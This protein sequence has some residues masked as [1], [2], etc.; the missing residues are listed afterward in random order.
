MAACLASGCYTGL[1]YA[2]EP[3]D[4][5][6]ADESGGSTGVGEEP[7][8]ASTSGGEEPPEADVCA[9]LPPRTRRLTMAQFD[10]LVAQIAPSFEGVPSEI[11]APTLVGSAARFEGAADELTMPA[12]H[13]DALLD[14][15]DDLSPAVLE[16]LDGWVSCDATAPDC[17]ESVVVAIAERFFRRPPSDDEVNRLVVFFEGVRADFGSDEALAL[18]VQAV[19][20][21]PQ[22]LYR[23]EVPSDDEPV[24]D[25]HQ[26]AEAMAYTLTDAPPDAELRAAAVDGTLRDAEVRRAHAERLLATPDSGAAILRFVRELLRSRRLDVLSLDPEVFPEFDGE[27]RASYHRELELFVESVVWDDDGSFADLLTEPRTFVDARLADLYGVSAPSGSADF[28]SVEH[29]DRSGLLTQGVYLARITNEHGDGTSIVGRGVSVREDFLCLEAPPPPDDV[30]D[31]LPTEVDD[32]PTTQRD[33]LALHSQGSCAGCHVQIDPFGYPFELFDQLGRPR[34]HE[35]GL[36]IDPS[37]ELLVG[38]ETIRVESVAELGQALSESRQARLCFGGHLL[39]FFDGVE[40]SEACSPEVGERPIRELL[41]DH[42]A[43]E[44]FIRRETP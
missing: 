20:L 14:L 40:R 25:G 23:V 41:V 12:P 35:Q 21:S 6:V 37:S 2:D 34:T 16:Q 8:D 31:D 27:L 44:D 28:E 26:I 3:T 32:G 9:P 5:D 29:E 7:E 42:V 1:P 4:E 15:A 36:P 10:A 19:I 24:L 18:L 39:L 13:V 30:D 22:T 11:L 38:A 17:A 33:R 43:S